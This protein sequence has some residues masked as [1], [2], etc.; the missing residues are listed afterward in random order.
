M[1]LFLC[2]QSVEQLKGQ[3]QA[4][5]AQRKTKTQTIRT[6]KQKLHQELP[7]YSASDKAAAL[8][9]GDGSLKSK[10][11]SF[12]EL[13]CLYQIAHKT[14]FQTVFEQAIKSENLCK[15]STPGWTS[16]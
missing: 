1:F 12:T 4:Y 3:R 13:I 16:Q 6:T 14:G 15:Q 10:S 8:S 7:F 2:F 9:H 11:H 5:Q